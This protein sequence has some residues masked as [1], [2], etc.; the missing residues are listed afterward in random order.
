MVMTRLSGV[1]WIGILFGVVAC[2]TS[3]SASAPPANASVAKPAPAESAPTASAAPTPAP[4]A[5]APEAA[6]SDL[7]SVYVY[8]LDWRSGGRAL[9]IRADG[10]GVLR[11]AEPLKDN[12]QVERRYE[13]PADAKRFEPVA[14]I[15]K[16]HDAVNMEINP[17][18]APGDFMAEVKLV[19][20]QGDAIRLRAAT[21][22][23]DNFRAMIEELR[24]AMEAISVD[25]LNQTYEGNK[26]HEWKPPVD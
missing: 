15:L 19:P 5:E 16:K 13:L 9:F 21:G 17:F 10:S 23:N 14:A 4:E 12:V 8:M 2:D 1:L 6:A 11:A 7:T 26:D 25:G 22:R 24:K 20:A 3:S 18:Q